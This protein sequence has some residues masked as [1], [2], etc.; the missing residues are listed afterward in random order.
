[1]TKE[2]RVWNTYV[3]EADR[4]DKELVEGRN[5]RF[6]EY[7][8]Y[9]VEF[10]MRTDPSTEQSSLG[11]GLEHMNYRRHCSLRFPLRKF[12]DLYGSCVMTDLKQDYAESSA[13]TLLVISQM[14]SAQDNPQNASLVTP[15]PSDAPYFSP[16]RTAV[17]VNSLWMLS[18]SLSVAVSL[19]AMLAKGW[20]YK[21]TSS[22]SGPA[23]EQA[24]RRQRK[25]NGIEKWKMDEV[26]TY[27]PGMLHLALLL[28]AI[29]LC[30]Y[31]WD[32]NVT[33]AM[34]V[35][36][37]AGSATLV[38]TL[39]TILPY[40]D[41]SC[42]YST[43]ASGIFTAINKIITFLLIPLPHALEVV[44]VGIKLA[45]KVI[46]FIPS[47]IDWMV[48]KL[49]SVLSGIPNLVLTI[50]ICSC[51][52]GAPLIPPIIAVVIAMAVPPFIFYLILRLLWVLVTLVRVSST[53]LWKLS[54]KL[55]KAL[56]RFLRFLIR[57][58][59]E[60][61]LDAEPNDAYN[62]KRKVPMDS[63]TS[64]ML[65]WL[66]SNC[67]DS[68]SVDTALQAIAG[69]DHNLPHQPLKDCGVFGLVSTRLDAY[70]VRDPK[71]KKYT[72]KD[73][74]QLPIALRYCRTYSIL[75]FG[76]T[77]QANK[78]GQSAYYKK[79]NQTKHAGA[80]ILAI[81]SIYTEYVV[82][83]LP[84]LRTKANRL[85]VSLLERAQGRGID[86]DV[87]ATA[88]A[89]AMPFSDSEW[90]YK[91]DRP[92]LA[93]ETAFSILAGH[94]Q[95]N[96]TMLSTSSLIALADF[97]PHYLL[98]AWSREEQ[99]DLQR[100]QHLLPMTLAQLF[101]KHYSTEPELARSSA[102]AL[103]AAAFAAN[104][105]Y[106]GEKPSKGPSGRKKRAA[107][108]LQHYQTNPPDTN[109]VLPLFIFGFY[110]LLPH[111]N[112]DLIDKHLPGLPDHLDKVLP[113]F[114]QFNL[115]D[116]QML[117]FTIPSNCSF[118]RHALLPAL[119]NL[120]A[121]VNDKPNDAD[122]IA[123][124]KFSPLLIHASKP[125]NDAD[126]KI[127]VLALVALCHAKHKV[128]QDL[129]MGII[130]KQPIPIDP[131]VLISA[132]DAGKDAGR[133]ATKGA[134]NL[135]GQLCGVLMANE[136]PVLHVTILHFELL[137]ARVISS[138]TRPLEELQS[139]L[140]PLLSSG[141]ESARL[142]GS[143]PLSLENLFFDLEKRQSERRTRDSMLV[144]MQYVADF[145]DHG[146]TLDENPRK[147]SDG[148]TESKDQAEQRWC[149][150]LWKLK[151]AYKSSAAKVERSNPGESGSP[152]PFN[153]GGVVNQ[154][155]GTSLRR[156]DAQ[157]ANEL[158]S[159]NGC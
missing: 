134:E 147:A 17:L 61:V 38:Y 25:W 68:R 149:E 76:A 119:E 46:D 32:I 122:H 21:F 6:I 45:P 30:L 54:E 8:A 136:T 28:F 101:F 93:P 85:R 15:G 19:I 2:A 75:I 111:L 117:P 97:V 110:E 11:A 98:W 67:E 49:E 152:F 109:T 79:D 125:A 113:G 44:T 18:L 146:L 52:I 127:Y 13:Q 95:S 84:I 24:R 31:L 105:Y 72:V 137:V 140:R 20:C 108:V 4:R 37:V 5:R 22:R 126:P 100:P 26:L 33:V 60:I 120:A 7:V 53:W 94:F 58:F 56:F 89:V 71:S 74:C 144:M 66:I 69:A 92:S 153:R 114:P 143:G 81:H 50:A 88:A 1:M 157:V 158:D 104:D 135:L 155:A 48:K 29:G 123:A 23:Y 57:S 99:A 80:G 47:K 138:M 112:F 90:Q 128:L 65:A 77:H 64:Q 91:S 41:H 40:V 116:N 107:Q 156:H 133:D 43:P 62:G 102:I 103:A 87:I 145:C 14:L 115:R 124:F 39:A 106:G 70:V 59:C 150:E 121:F 27:L 36:V 83:S 139:V 132:C 9:A 96:C 142:I 51:G 148:G 78:G 10:V 141:R 154:E 42:P 129:L 86:P 3:W 159:L 73:P 131:L 12:N 118:E 55:F 82:L 130:D 35:V 16:S 63:L 34:P 151:N